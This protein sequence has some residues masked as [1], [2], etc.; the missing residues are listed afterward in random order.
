MLKMTAMMFLTPRKANMKQT[1]ARILRRGSD[2]RIPRVLVDIV[3]KKTALK[4]QAGA[5]A[6]AMT[7]YGFER[8]EIYVNWSDIKIKE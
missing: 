7:F 4:Y 6:I 1:I 8:E 2:L 5:R 3:D